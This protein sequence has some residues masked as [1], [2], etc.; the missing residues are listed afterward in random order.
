MTSST[1]HSLGRRDKQSQGKLRSETLI[2]NLVEFLH[3]RVDEL[4]WEDVAD[5]IWLAAHLR[6]ASVRSMHL[7]DSATPLQHSTKTDT[8]RPPK[9]IAKTPALA[10]VHASSAKPAQKR[11]ESSE[12]HNA[13][14]GKNSGAVR[15]VP[16]QAATPPALRDPLAI[17][18]ALRPLRFLRRSRGIS[19]S[20]RRPP[21][22]WPLIPACGFQSSNRERPALLSW[23]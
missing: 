18:R 10:D 6:M 20:M 9:P 12:T 15:G 4:S 1:H 17:G 22:G 23:L 8:N 7:P 3:S 5:S 16:L 13:P 2:Q 14:E 11:T 19:S 21:S